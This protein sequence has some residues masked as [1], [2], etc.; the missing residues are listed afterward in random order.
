MTIN[1]FRKRF[2]T[3]D[4]CLHFLIEQKWGNGYTCYKCKCTEFI[5]GRKWF[6]RRCKN[7]KYDESVTSNTIFHKCKMDLLKVFEMAYR[8]TVKKKGMSTCELAKEF[9]CQQKSA[10]LLK[11]KLQH[12]MKSSGNYPLEEEVEVDEFLVGGMEE[13]MR[14]RSHGDKTLVVLGIEKVINKKGIETIG[15]AYAKVI[16]AASALNLKTFFEESVSKD[17]Q[18]TTDGWKGYIPLK[19]DWQITQ[20]ISEKGKAFPIIHTHI[21]NIKGWLRGVHHKCSSVNLQNYL[22]E[23]HFRFNRRSNLNSIVDKLLSRAMKHNPLP[24]KLIKSELNT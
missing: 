4:D 1:D 11:S 2:S 14:G 22:D 20:T 16:Q 23:Y 9:G 6:Y 10:W 24:Y 21:M 13:N 19:K 3:T 18:V 17:A 7:C 12:T 5:K 8:I 15:R